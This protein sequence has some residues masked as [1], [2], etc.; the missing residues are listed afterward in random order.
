MVVTFLNMYNKNQFF[1][2][3][4]GKYKNINLNILLTKNKY[5]KT[6]ITYNKNEQKMIINL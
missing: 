3:T 4:L 1:Y 5:K 6:M 2:N